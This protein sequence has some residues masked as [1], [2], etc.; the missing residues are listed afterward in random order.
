M[1][2][3]KL[4][5]LGWDG[6]SSSLMPSGVLRCR[7]HPAPSTLHPAAPHTIPQASG[8][9]A[10]RRS[11]PRSRRLGFSELNSKSALPTGNRCPVPNRAGVQRLGSAGAVCRAAFPAL[12]CTLSA[13]CLLRAK[14]KTRL[15]GASGKALQI[16]RHVCC[17]SR[18]SR[19]G[20]TATRAP[21]SLCCSS[22]NSSVH[23]SHK[24]QQGR[25]E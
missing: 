10:S 17:S 2:P 12:K 5:S 20:C 24:K 4:L 9:T 22:R 25:Y 16:F 13:H 11:E 15:V 21:C 18:Q 6:S 3:I 8:V 14:G 23:G 1:N 19:A 7:G